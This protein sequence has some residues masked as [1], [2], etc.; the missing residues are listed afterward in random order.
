M[1]QIIPIGIFKRNIRGYICYYY[2]RVQ[3]GMDDEMVF[4]LRKRIFASLVEGYPNQAIAASALGLSG[5]AQVSHL[6][7]GEKN[8]GEKLAR[9]IE[10][11]ARL[12][13]GTLLTPQ[14]VSSNVTV[15]NDAENPTVDGAVPLIDWV[16]VSE[17]IGGMMLEKQTKIKQKPFS[18]T[19][20]HGEKSFALRVIG[21]SMRNSSNTR[22]TYFNDDVILVDPSRDAKNTD[23]IIAI[24]DDESIP[25]E[26]RIVFKQ[27]IEDGPMQYL[28]S[29][30]SSYSDITAPFKIIGV[31]FSSISE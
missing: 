1:S 10:S 24:L 6:V 19:K 20:I 8:I 16:D 30:N 23:C 27:L 11:K 22:P 7:T 5:A 17:W 29:L 31:V 9:R 3:S 25:L 13:F 4:R 12:P 18:T 14:N 28:R 21:D 15:I 2:L 26:R